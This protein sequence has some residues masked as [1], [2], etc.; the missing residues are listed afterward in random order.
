MEKDIAENEEHIL[1][2]PH[3]EFTLCFHRKT[4]NRSR[5]NNWIATQ[6]VSIITY[7]A[8]YAYNDIYLYIDCRRIKLDG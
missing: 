7:D 6:P 3:K 2:Y 1:K 5:Y 4:F 8:T